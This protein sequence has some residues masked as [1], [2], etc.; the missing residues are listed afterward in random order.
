MFIALRQLTVNIKRKQRHFITPQFKYTLIRVGFLELCF[1]HYS[2]CGLHKLQA[3]AVKA[4]I[5]LIY[6]LKA[7]FTT[8]TDIDAAIL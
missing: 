8:D 6:T 3:I 5:K 2:Y 1:L 4:V 7:E